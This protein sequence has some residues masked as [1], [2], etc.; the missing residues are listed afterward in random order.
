MN[1]KIKD[2][3]TNNVLKILFSHFKLNYNRDIFKRLKEHPDYPSFLSFNHILRQEGINS[4]A[5]QTTVEEIRDELP[6]PV[7]IFLNKTINLFLIV[8]QVD[9]SDFYI[10]NEKGD[11]EKNSIELIKYFW[12][13]KVMIFDT[14]NIKRK[15]IS[16]REKVFI[17][18]NNLRAPFLATSLLFVFTFMLLKNFESRSLFNYAYL[19]LSLIGFILSLI[20]VI[21]DIDE[22]NTLIQ[23]FC[24]SDKKNS[25]NCKLPSYSKF[26]FFGGIFLWSDIGLVYFAFISFLVLIIPSELSVIIAGVLSFLSFPYVL[27]SVTF[28]KFIAREWCLLCL[29]VQ[30]ILSLKV[31]TSLLFFHSN[32]NS[33][34][35][36]IGDLIYPL[37]IFISVCAIYVSIKPIISKIFEIERV[38][39]NHLSL[40]HNIE[41]KELLFKNQQKLTSADNYCLIL[42]NPN[43]KTIITLVISPTCIPCLNELMVLIPILRSKFDTRIE[44]IFFTETEEKDYLSFQLSWKLIGSHQNIL[45]NFWEILWHYVSN[46]PYSKFKHNWYVGGIS[47]EKEEEYRTILV[48]QRNWCISNE[49]F[50]TPSVFINE[51]RL[52]YYYSVKEI[53][54]MCK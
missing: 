47:E 4:L 34:N 54:Y 12:D 42:G 49:L 11:S 22:H 25:I 32:N 1:R 30:I 21:G 27:Y 41:V 13:G 33:Y 24:L 5:L 38:T 8:T 52:P 9:N 48:K 3:N 44:L 2:Y 18:I 15:K 16:F 50:S 31:I 26:S 29:G 20:I 10:L 17:T 23:K 45:H 43:G 40:K 36:E 14:K 53:D 7:L 35:L 6:K 51:R 28:Q 37:I 19:L 39:A 46:Y